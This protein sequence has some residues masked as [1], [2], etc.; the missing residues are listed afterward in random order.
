MIHT[1]DKL[2]FKALGKV[3]HWTNRQGRAYCLRQ[4]QRRFRRLMEAQNPHLN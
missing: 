1:L 4:K 2:W 3:Y